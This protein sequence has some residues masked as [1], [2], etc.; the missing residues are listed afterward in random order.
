MCP[1]LPWIHAL[2]DGELSGEQAVRSRAH[3]AACAVCQE[4]FT[5]LVQ[6][7]LASSPAVIARCRMPMVRWRPRRR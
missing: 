3:L 1:E 2:V 7:A 4:E 6:L 5:W